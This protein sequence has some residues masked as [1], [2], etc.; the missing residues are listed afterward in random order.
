MQHYSATPP[1]P[2][3]KGRFAPWSSLLCSLCYLCYLL[4]TVYPHVYQ[5][6]IQP[7][8]HSTIQQTACPIQIG[9]ASLSGIASYSRM[10]RRH[11]SASALPSTTASPG[12]S[13]SCPPSACRYQPVSLFLRV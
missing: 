10:V 8:N 6:S 11:L 2:G 4:F 3:K 12:S 5:K 7:F 1:E 13:V 9:H